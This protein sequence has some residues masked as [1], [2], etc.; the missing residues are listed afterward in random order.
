[1]NWKKILKNIFPEEGESMEEYMERT[2]TDKKIISPEQVR[3]FKNR[4]VKPT[5]LQERDARFTSD[6]NAFSELIESEYCHYVKDYNLDPKSLII[7]GEFKKPLDELVYKR[8]SH[9]SAYSLIHTIYF[10][11]LYNIVRE[12]G[13]N[14]IFNEELYNI[15]ILNMETLDKISSKKIPYNNYHLIDIDM[16]GINN[17]LGTACNFLDDMFD[18]F[19][20]SAPF[21]SYIHGRRIENSKSSPDCKKLLESLPSY[22]GMKTARG[23]RVPQE[24]R[25]QIP[26]SLFNILHYAANELVEQNDSYIVH[27]VCKFYI[28]SN[29]RS[30]I[31]KVYTVFFSTEEEMY[32]LIKNYRNL[33]EPFIEDTPTTSRNLFGSKNLKVT[34]FRPHLNRLG[35][36]NILETLYVGVGNF[37]KIIPKSAK[38]F[39]EEF[40]RIFD[41]AFSS[42]ITDREKE[43]IRAG[44][45]SRS[46]MVP[47]W[48]GEV[49]K[50]LLQE[51]VDD[52]FT[53]L[54]DII[55]QGTKNGLSKSDYNESFMRN[56]YYALENIDEL[57]LSEEDYREYIWLTMEEQIRETA[58]ESVYINVYNEEEEEDADILYNTV[59]QRIDEFFRYF[60]H[61]LLDDADI[62][63]VIN[64]MNTGPS[65]VQRARMEG[66][67][68]NPQDY[69]GRGRETGRI[70]TEPVEDMPDEDREEQ[71][72]EERLRRPRNG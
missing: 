27:G 18:V 72:L 46:S 2:G 32:G 55:E 24:E 58:E 34:R 15:E 67:R 36:R 51:E 4:P 17:T 9:T 41:I 47:E 48:F 21:K 60:S 8:H 37:P 5:E 13:G 54:M 40:S 12:N 30:Q 14:L 65:G 68:I 69:S 62:Q 42:E 16:K 59:T 44:Y 70:N 28:P 64:Y 1:M 49:A 57:K 63:S 7:V 43:R 20:L 10:N 22:K 45:Q 25:S 23:E 29:Y 31:G 26:T 66:N 52:F 33:L 38:L 39:K 53:K 6:T 11:K 35:E 71:E 3:G 56:M 19:S 61:E 50:I